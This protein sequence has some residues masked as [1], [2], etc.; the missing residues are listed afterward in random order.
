MC[1]LDVAIRLEQIDQYV[2]LKKDSDQ[3]GVL[4][5]TQFLGGEEATDPS[6]SFPKI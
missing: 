4:L 3:A 5:L 6:I 2:T 1:K